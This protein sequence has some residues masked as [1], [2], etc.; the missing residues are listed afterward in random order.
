MTSKH[1]TGVGSRQTPV[2]VLHLM[3]RLGR[4][5]TDLGYK[6]RSGDAPGSDRAFYYGAKLSKNY[7]ECLPEIYIVEDGFRGR[8][9]DGEEFY[10]VSSFS[11]KD[12]ARELAKETRGNFHG[13]KE[14][15]IE[16]HT[17]NTYQVL[18]KDLD[19]VSDII[20]SYCKLDRNNKPTGGTATAIKLANKVGVP[21]NK[22]L[23]LDEDYQWCVEWLAEHESHEP[24]EKIDWSQI[25]DT[26]LDYDP[27]KDGVDHIN[28]YSKSR[29]E[30]G[31]L[32]SNWSE[33]MFIHPELGMFKTMEGFYAFLATEMKY[34]YLRMV[35]GYEAKMKLKELTRE[36]KRGYIDELQRA[37]TYKFEQ[38][39]R[40]QEL[41][42]EYKDLPITHY[43]WY[44]EIGNNP[45]II[46]NSGDT[47][48]EDGWNRIKQNYISKRTL[49]LEKEN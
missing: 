2:K 42:W 10:D 48:L 6:L 26:K 19:N 12:K 32:L 28:I 47:W 45:R 16:L 15:G 43:Y 29:S 30:L 24:Y 22:N 40:I 11:N 7:K 38:S 46:P 34:D 39:P 27:G 20:F 17:R 33:T 8:R 25:L 21:I 37:L 9:T 18:G 23:Y 36:Q 14:L 5:A 31:R 41:M 49:E 13:L 4:T 1:F 44:G 3:V 35:N